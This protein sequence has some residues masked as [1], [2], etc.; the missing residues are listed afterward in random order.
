MR[1]QIQQL[2]TKHRLEHVSSQIE[3]ASLPAIHISKSGSDSPILGASRIGGLPDV[4][5]E[6]NWLQWQGKPLGFLAQ[7]S[8]AELSA[9]DL[10]H[11]LP[12]S[13]MLYFFYDITEQPWG[14]DPK[15]Q[16]SSAVIYIPTTDAL[17]QAVLPA[18]WEMDELCL[19]PFYLE[20]NRVPSLP[21][22]GSTAFKQMGLADQEVDNYLEL[23]DEVRERFTQTKPLH[24]LLGHANAIQGDMQMKC[25]LV[26]H[27][28]Y[29][30]DESGYADPL[31]K[32]LEGGASEWRL[33]F[34]VDS[35]D[36]IGS[37]WGDVGMVYFWIR[38]SSLQQRK[39][40]ETWTIL[41][42]L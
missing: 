13:G 5:L 31:A 23:F 32:A 7:I 1:E 16:G 17:T 20:F 30:G 39:F 3:E 33:L 41:Q 42:C 36:D 8:C 40:D 6:F 29:C 26:S 37:M 2:I 12:N 10:E 34:Q 4:P 35:D 15:H 25:Q 21:A 22:Y 9:C 19:N 24:Q 38:E 14:F 18:D 28:L 27:G 11:T